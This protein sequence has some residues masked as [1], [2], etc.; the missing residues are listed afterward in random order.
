VYKLTIANDTWTNITPAAP[1]SNWQ[2]GYGGLAVDPRNPNTIVV[3]TI[4]RWSTG[5]DLYKSTDG[6]ANWT[7][8]NAVSTHVAPNN[9]WVAA[10]YGGS[11]AGKM[12]HWITDVDIDPFNSDN[13]MYNTGYGLWESNNLTSA[14]VAWSFNDSGIEETGQYAPMVS[15]SS[16][17]AHLFMA[18]GDV[19]GA[20][21]GTDFNSVAGYYSNPNSSNYGVDVADQNPNIVARTVARNNALMLSL[22][23]G[24]TWT[25]S[26]S[27]PVTGSGDAGRVA[28]SAKGTSLLWVP[29][30]QGAY[31]STNGGAS[32]TASSGYP[33]S[34]AVYS[35]SYFTPV[36]DK[37][38]DGYFYTYDFSKGAILESADNGSSF[39]TIYTGLNVLPDYASRS[40]LA[41][42]PGTKRRDLWL[43]T[44]NG[45]WHINGTGAT[46]VQIPNVQVATGVGFGMAAAGANYPAVYFTGK[47]N[48]VQG[49]F[50]SL[51]GGTT[52][53]RIN[54][55]KHQWGGPGW[56]TG[57]MRIFGRVY[58]SGGR[59]GVI[60]GDMQ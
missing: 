15:P 43:A 1:T 27:S 54:D 3:T 7:A 22:D 29:G 26:A 53:T 39:A 46:P 13:V 17:G 45:L 19:A 10:Y 2:F 28:V 32:W 58:V 44:P 25:Q 59:G 52:W 57:D 49:V 38:A 33:V 8:L 11:L 47:Y 36:A 55:D 50:Q 5:D 34:Q 51:D 14:A 4:D 18:L 21:Y 30:G 48:N 40:Q 37:A 20:R 6:G 42:V 24:V 16:G 12:G 9:P 41:S 35:G 31:V 23:N 60:I 56:V